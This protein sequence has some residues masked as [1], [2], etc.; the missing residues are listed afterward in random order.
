MAPLA[1]RAS[2]SVNDGNLED[3]KLS[4]IV[5]RLKLISRRPSPTPDNPALSGVAGTSPTETSPSWQRFASRRRGPVENVPS[6][7]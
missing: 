7:S 3:S 1:R 4:Q 6:P 5:A 2:L